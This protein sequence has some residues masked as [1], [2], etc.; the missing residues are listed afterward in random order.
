MPSRGPSRN[1][2]QHHTLCAGGSLKPSVGGSIYLSVIASCS[3][4]NIPPGGNQNATF[5][6]LKKQPNAV[7]A[8]VA[9]AGRNC[10]Q[11]LPPD[12]GSQNTCSQ[13]DW[14]TLFLYSSADLVPC[15]NMVC[16]INNFFTECMGDRA[17]P[18]P[19]PDDYC[20]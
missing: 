20:D 2:S 9:T 17:T 1:H 19:L 3:G 12:D 8:C 5:R 4:F 7:N 6:Y 13:K 14:C 10:Q 15:T 11:C 18:N 16:Y